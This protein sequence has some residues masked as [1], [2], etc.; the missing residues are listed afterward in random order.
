MIGRV[1]GPHLIPVKRRRGELLGYYGTHYV[2]DAA[3]E[4]NAH[5]SGAEGTRQ[6]VFEPKSARQDWAP[7]QLE[8]NDGNNGKWQG[9]GAGGDMHGGAGPPRLL[10]TLR[11]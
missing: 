1:S 10:S 5:G 8:G 6:D 4:T 11:L 2:Y 7:Y 9:V 3:M